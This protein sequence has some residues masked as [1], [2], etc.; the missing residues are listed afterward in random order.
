MDA[1]T[2]QVEP[3]H[4]VPRLQWEHLYVTEQMSVM[5]PIRIHREEVCRLELGVRMLE[6]WRG[7]FGDVSP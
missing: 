5:R 1:L 3:G 4:D 2:V 7:H 6:V